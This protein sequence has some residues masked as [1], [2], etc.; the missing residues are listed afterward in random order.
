MKVSPVARTE[1]LIVKEVDGETLVYDTKTDEAHCLNETAALVWKNCDGQKSVSEIAQFLSAQSNSEVKDEIVWLALDQLTR[2]KLLQEAPPKPALFAGLT[3]RQ[4]VAR[5]GIAAVAI[6]AII[7]IVSPTA[8]A[9]GASCIPTGSP[10]CCVSPNDCCF[11]QCDP[12][13][14]P[15][16][17]Y[18]PNPQQ[19]GKQCLG[20]I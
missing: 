6:P 10:F 8:L 17:V 5:L 13:P 16:N 1:S 7:S 18:P 12:A 20:R 14:T 4:M 19:S 15:C 2:F 3:R 11:G 9:A